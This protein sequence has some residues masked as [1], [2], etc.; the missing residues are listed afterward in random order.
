MYRVFDKKEK[1]WVKDGIYLSPNNDLST[2]KKAIFGIFL[3]MVEY[4]LRK[5][6]GIR[7]W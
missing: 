3:C 6:K 1:C 4:V 2:S 5:L 7:P